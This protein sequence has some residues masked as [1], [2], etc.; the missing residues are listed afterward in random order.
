MARR[1]ILT[2]FLTVS[3]LVGLLFLLSI[4][5]SDHARAARWAPPRRPLPSAF[6][7]ET[8]TTTQAITPT[9]AITTT[10]LVTGT[11][12]TPVEVQAVNAVT[13]TVP[14]EATPTPAP[15]DPLPVVPLQPDE[16]LTGTIVLNRSAG[17]IFFFLGN[18]LYELP[19]N[20][21]TGLHFSPPLAAL[22]LFS[23]P[24]SAE[25]DPACDWI[26]HPVR[27]NGFYHVATD[28]DSPPPAN[29]QLKAAEAPPLDTIWIQNRSGAEAQMLFADQIVT[30]TNTSVIALT[31]PP[32]SDALYLPHCLQTSEQ[33]ICE[34][35]PAPVTGGVYYALH[36]SQ[37]PAGINGVTVTRGELEALM[38]QE[39][40]MTPTPTPE[41]P[42]AGILCQVQIP[43]LNVRSGPGLNYLITGK[44]RTSSEN[45][46]QVLAVGRTESGEWLAVDPHFVSGGWIVNVPQWLTCDGDIDQL[47]VA[48]I[49][50][51]RLAR[52][53]P[54][55]TPTPEPTATP[56]PKEPQAA[57]PVPGPQQALLI[58]TNVFEH[59]IRFTLDATQHGLPPGSPSEYD[60]KPRQS[61]RFIIRAGRVQFSAS[62]AWRGGSGNAE[63]ELAEGATRE[64]FLHFVPAENDQDRWELRFDR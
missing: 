62:T 25:D 15:T 47:P 48:K 33:R 21:A 51:G 23:C 8:V 2:P 39:A 63:F 61:L 45:R 36:E 13:V 32:A 64:L 26:S 54:I 30:A 24:V 7:Q 12:M 22:V 53:T 19:A 10:Q 9:E 17:S 52:P 37:K 4:S 60:L 50:D 6:A 14:A 43:A 49:S 56:Q 42:P 57:A 29:L 27:R 16:V 44:L 58:A 3:L 40:L 46:G 1:S 11:P 38:M 59:T 55:P 34:W 20:R 31:P 41:P 35:L 28:P 18:D 5:G